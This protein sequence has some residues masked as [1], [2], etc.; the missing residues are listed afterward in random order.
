MYLVEY[1]T[2]LNSNSNNYNLEHC[3]ENLKS[4]LVVKFYP[5]CD[6]NK[7]MNVSGDDGVSSTSWLYSNELFLN[8]GN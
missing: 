8:S 1:Q 3:F 2:V 7:T 6:S 5:L 4:D